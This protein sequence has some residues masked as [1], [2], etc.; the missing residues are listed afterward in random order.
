MLMWIFFW[1]L[2][3]VLILGAVTWREWRAE[4]WGCVTVGD[5]IRLIVS[6]LIWPVPIVII[7]DERDWLDLPI[8]DL[9]WFRKEKNDD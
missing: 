4:D 7:A 9:D 3:G 5:V 1:W 2:L 6:P 8:F